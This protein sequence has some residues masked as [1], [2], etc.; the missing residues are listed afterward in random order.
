LPIV[1]LLADTRV[2]LYYSARD[3]RGRAQIGRARVDLEGG[4]PEFDIEPVVRLGAGGAFDESGVTGGCLVEHQGRQHLFYSG[5]TLPPDVPFL[6]FIGAAVSTD[7]EHFE[8]VSTAPLLP[9]SGTDPFLTASPSILIE[10]GVW[11]MWYVSGTGWNGREPSYRICYAESPDGFTWKSTGKVC[12]DYSYEGE[13]AIARP[14]VIK[15][16]STYRMWFS[17]RGDKYR[18]GYAESDDGLA[19]KRMDAEAGIDVSASG[20]DSEMIE[21]PWVGDLGG[22]RR[23]L[24]NGNGYGRT[25]IGQATLQ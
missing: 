12:I 4:Q 8:K 20:W 5:W 23:M 18:L 9:R 25:G 1:R 13:H 19:W 21:Y 16:G 10:D 3:E 22:V 17:H 15:D 24:Y 14:H 11:R 6:F 2:H 7:G